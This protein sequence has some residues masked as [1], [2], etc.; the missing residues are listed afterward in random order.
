MILIN[1][2]FWDDAMILINKKFW[3]LGFIGKYFIKARNVEIDS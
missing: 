2:K 1:K 3:D